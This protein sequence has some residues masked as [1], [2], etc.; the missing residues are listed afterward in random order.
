M[1]DLSKQEEY[2][3]YLGIGSRV[4]VGRFSGKCDRT[5]A[6][7]HSILKV[8]GKEALKYTFDMDRA[9]DHKNKSLRAWRKQGLRRIYIKV[10]E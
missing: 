6:A 5:I 2:D 7:N 8:T 3:C 4:N 9:I 10:G 1:L